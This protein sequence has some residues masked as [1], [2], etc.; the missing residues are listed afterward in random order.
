MALSSRSRTLSGR[1]KSPPGPEAPRAPTQTFATAG[2]AG[3]VRSSLTNRILMTVVAW[4]E[5]LNVK[6]AKLGNPCV[7]DN[8]LFSWVAAIEREWRT[9]RRELESV[10]TRK[11]DLASFQD[12]S[13]DVAT[14]TRDAGWKTFLFTGYGV[15][16]RRNTALCPETWRIVQRVP[17][18]KTA[19]FSIFEPGK[20]LPAHR[21]PYNGVLRL[22][23]G[24]MVPEPRENAAI[25]VG[26]QILHWQEGRVLIFDDAYEHEAWNRTGALRV[27]LFV[28][29]VRPLRF[30]ANLLNW[31]LLNVAVFTPYVREGYDNHRKWERRFYA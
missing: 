28:D 21:G 15:S 1:T 27:V 30:P 17:G 6:Y 14:I 25:R 11:D 3:M 19:M 22:H 23:L 7:Y 13:A 4:V 10:L 26:P 29:F 12:I 31:L 18:L 24:L 8:A 2:L 9:I 20:H 16:S 5:R